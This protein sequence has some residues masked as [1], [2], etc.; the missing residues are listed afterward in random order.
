MK[1]QNQNNYSTQRF[2][3]ALHMDEAKIASSIGERAASVAI[4]ARTELEVLANEKDKFGNDLVNIIIGPQ[5]GSKSE[6]NILAI[7]IQDFIP[8]PIKSKTPIIAP[9][10]NFGRRFNYNFKVVSTRRTEGWIKTEAE[11][12][13]DKALVKHT[14]SMI[15]EFKGDKLLRKILEYVS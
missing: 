10:I 11:S 8:A 12:F 14:D 4:A 3:M 6:N 1:V 13:S 7:W 9:L 2:G 15:G 5:K